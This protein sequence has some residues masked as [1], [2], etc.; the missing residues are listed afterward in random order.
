MKLASPVALLVL[1]AALLT[2]CGGGLPSR[3]SSSR[4][5]DATAL[6]LRQEAEQVQ[7]LNDLNAARA[8]EIAATDAVI[9]ATSTQR[10]WNITATRV[11]RPT[12]TATSTPLPSATATPEPT[13]T[14]APTW[15]P[16]PTWT[17]TPTLEP[18]YT[19]TSE[20]TERVIQNATPIATPIA[21]P[22]SADLI[23]FLFPAGVITAVLLVLLGVAF[24]AVRPRV[25]YEPLEGEDRDGQ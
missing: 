18:T 24:V 6:A 11:A 9:N 15:T 19:Q 16:V 8:A 25:H 7:V 17:A 3:D 13:E 23:S 2:A 1:A 5:A 20:P 22:G 12:E 10:A 4:A 14:F 21:T